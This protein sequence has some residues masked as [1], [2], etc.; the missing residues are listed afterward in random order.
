MSQP[1][2]LRGYSD[3]STETLSVLV[4]MLEDLTAPVRCNL[5]SL[6]L[7][8]LRGAERAYGGGGFGSPRGTGDCF[9]Q[10]AILWVAEGWTKRPG[11]VS[12]SPLPPAIYT[13]IAGGSYQ[14][15]SKSQVPSRQKANLI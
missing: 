3:R 14:N 13:A 15:P 12:F 8:H 4:F 2:E 9:V 1:M 11:R 10:G 5:H 7:Q 6:H